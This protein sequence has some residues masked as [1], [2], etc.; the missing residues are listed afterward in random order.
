MKTAFSVSVMLLLL[1]TV[2][3][4]ASGQEQDAEGTA[5]FAGGCFWCM[6]EAYEKHDGVLEV[7]SGYTGGHVEDP[8]Y[9]QVTGGNTGH[10]EAVR[11]QYD[12]SVISYE[13]LIDIFW[14]NVDPLDSGG[15]FCD[16]GSSYLSGIFFLNDKQET[17]AR[18]SLEELKESGRFSRPIATELSEAGEFY[19]AE[20]YHQ[21][22]YR[23]NPLRYKLYKRACGR[24]ARLNELW[25]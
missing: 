20:Q 11:V 10:H 14:R 12:P 24:E 3:P 19:V 1:F 5:I 8:S 17:I 4:A 13:Q 21:D 7:V 9:Q 15:Q 18:E 6:E 2:L 25:G 16:R 22:Y 23:K